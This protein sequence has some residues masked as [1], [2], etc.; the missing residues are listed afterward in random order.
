MDGVEQTHE[1]TRAHDGRQSVGK[2]GGLFEAVQSSLVAVR[3]DSPTLG[4]EHVGSVG[5]G[6]HALLCR[7]C[8][9]VVAEQDCISI[10]PWND[11][12]D[13]DIIEAM[14]ES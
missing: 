12:D 2:C 3:G 11:D 7:L 14:L 8:G 4:L 6:Y 10:E 9:P 13:I 5:G 1:C